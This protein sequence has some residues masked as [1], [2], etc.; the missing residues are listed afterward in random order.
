MDT[1]I[2]TL[3]WFDDQVLDEL[4]IND[5]ME[6]IL[7]EADIKYD[8]L[9]ALIM[10]NKTKILYSVKF[11]KI[12]LVLDKYDY[13]DKNI[14]RDVLINDDKFINGDYINKLEGNILLRFIG[15]YYEG[16]YTR[17]KVT[18]KTEFNILKQVNN[19]LKELI[20]HVELSYN[21]LDNDLK[22]LFITHI[23]WNENITDECLKHL[24]SLQSL[25]IY[26][27]RNITDKGLKYI[28][29]LQSLNMIYDENI[30]NEGLKHLPLLQS[31][32]MVRNENITDEGLKYLPLLRSLNLFWNENI[33]D[34]GLR[35]LPLLQS[36]YMHCNK[37]ITDEGLKH[38]PL[39]QSL[40]MCQNENITDGGL[41]HLPLLQLLSIYGNKNVTDEGLKHLSSLQSLD[42]YCNTNIA[43]EGLK[44]LKL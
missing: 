42:I 3:K 8:E 12:W 19:K 7:K 38:L 32:N 22:G 44:H 30:T 23:F 11:A 29:K 36:L 21:A 15:A 1:I 41:K 33:T 31:L 28:P 37:N 35:H 14:L 20:D 13:K 16:D 4:E 25:E 40:V 2:E 34:G 39:L 5:V 10:E 24:P 9:Y 17:Y 6:I 43:D 26:R 27:N 18:N